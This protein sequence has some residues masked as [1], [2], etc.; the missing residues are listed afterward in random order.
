M[1]TI[2]PERY[3]VALR[4]GICRCWCA[5]SAQCPRERGHPAVFSAESKDTSK[6]R[7]DGQSGLIGACGAPFAPERESSEIDARA[8]HM[9][10]QYQY[11]G[12]TR[13]ESCL[14]LLRRLLSHQNICI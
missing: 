10:N 9:H 7:Q 4:K 8:A 1:R 12:V 3:T 14:C 11:D 13:T 6:A 5:T 2:R